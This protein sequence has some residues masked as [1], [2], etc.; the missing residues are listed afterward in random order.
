MRVVTSTS[1][2]TAGAGLALAAAA[3]PV[4]IAGGVD[5]PVVPPG[6]L[7]LAASA[8]I[9]L[10]VPPRW[11]LLLPTTAAVFLSVGAVVT[12]NVR[13]ALGDPGETLAFTGTLVQCA[14]LAVGLVFCVLSLVERRRNGT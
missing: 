13:D 9:A 4:Q 6:L 5:Y 8:A 2:R 10:L 14:G 12:E 3:I 11:A 1:R 7:I